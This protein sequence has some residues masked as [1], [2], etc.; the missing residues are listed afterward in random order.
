MYEINLLKCKLDI[1]NVTHIR[2]KFSEMTKKSFLTI[3]FRCFHA[4]LV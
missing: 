3:L 4:T 1:I 2:N